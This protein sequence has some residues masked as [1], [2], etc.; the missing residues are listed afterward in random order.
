MKPLTDIR[1]RICN[2]PL[3]HVTQVSYWVSTEICMCPHVR[4][5]VGVVETFIKLALALRKLR[6]YNTLYAVVTGLNHGAV[7]RMRRTWEVWAGPVGAYVS[8]LRVGR[9]RDLSFWMWSAVY[10]QTDNAIG[11]ST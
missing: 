2:P 7:Q 1:P 5:R 11:Q 4:T 6:N 10:P 3:L 9:V 8:V